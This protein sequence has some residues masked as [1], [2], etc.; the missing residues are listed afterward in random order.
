M[1]ACLRSVM[2]SPRDWLVPLVLMPDS[3]ATGALPPEKR[4]DMSRVDVLYLACVCLLRFETRLA[5]PGPLA[6]CD[7]RDL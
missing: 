2:V 3:E 7:G 1:C 5:P 4:A 6:L